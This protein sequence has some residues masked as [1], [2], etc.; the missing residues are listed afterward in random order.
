MR[1]RE[2]REEEIC[3]VAS[4]DAVGLRVQQSNLHDAPIR[5]GHRTTVCAGSEEE[6][7][8]GSTLSSFQSAR[9]REIPTFVV[10]TS[11]HK[12]SVQCLISELVPKMGTPPQIAGLR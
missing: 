6:A 3:N 10:Q 1:A 5:E 7:R 2:Q 8:T 11:P 12:K 4:E 9:G